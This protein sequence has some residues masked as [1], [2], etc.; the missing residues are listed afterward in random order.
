MVSHKRKVILAVSCFILVIFNQG[1]QD[2]FTSSSE[3]QDFPDLQFDERIY[4]FGVAGQQEKITHEYGFTNA[5][6][7]ILTIET[8]KTSCGCVATLL[9]SKEIPPADTGVITASFETRKYK[10]EQVETIHVHSNDPDEP[11]IELK[12]T[13]VI[14]TEVAVEPEFLYFG[15]VE[16]GKAITKTLKLIQ[17]GAGQ[18]GL[19]QVEAAEEY[20]VTHVSGLED[21]RH[22]GFKIDVVLRSD[23]PIGRFTEA[24]T[25]HT[26]VNK[27]PRI[28]VPVCGNVLGRIRVKPQ[29][30]SLGTLKK[31]SFAANKIETTSTDQKSYDIL[32]VISNPPF[33]VT[34][35]T[36]GKND[37]DFKIAV[38]VDENAPAGRVGGEI[39]IYTDDPDQSL[40]KVPVYGII[41]NLYAVGS[42]AETVAP[43]AGD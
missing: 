41:T 43:E 27:R 12:I 25:L 23:A 18:L 6:K 10:G 30:L 5:G 26:N 4:N 42:P 21:E 20:F 22:K 1:C 29:M 17:I 36:R 28:D 31:G 8:V 3:Q 34:E 38:K 33:F 19:N 11:E 40:I 2:S 7:G 13:G 14:K 32:K 24:V 37:R 35:V 39:Y 9:S 16:K 15:D